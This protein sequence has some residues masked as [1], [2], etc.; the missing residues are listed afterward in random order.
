[1]AATDRK[2]SFSRGMTYNDQNMGDFSTGVGD[3]N[4]DGFDDITIAGFFIEESFIVFGS[5]TPPALMSGLDLT[6]D[7]GADG[8]R[9]FVLRGYDFAAFFTKSVAAGDVNA[10]GL[11]IC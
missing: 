10:D 5:G 11:P 8:T 6:S 9:G 1:M 2:A 4:G 3:I 7:D